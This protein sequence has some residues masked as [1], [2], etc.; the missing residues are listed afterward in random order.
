M[1]AMDKII[2]PQI[3]QIP[4]KESRDPRSYAIIGAGLEVHR[5]LGTGFLESVYQEA[6][7]LEFRERQI[8]FEKE[9]SFPVIYKGHTLTSIFRADFVCFEQIIV[10]LKALSRLSGNEEAQIINYLKATELKVG[11]LL[12]FGTPSL[13]YRRFVY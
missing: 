12:N 10:E 8:P 4:Q 7:E 1:T 13:Q 11:L 2:N 9:K 6:L 3:A 5:E